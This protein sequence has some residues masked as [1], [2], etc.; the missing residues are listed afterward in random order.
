MDTAPGERS[1]RALRAERN[2]SP[3]PTSAVIDASAVDDGALS[4]SVASSDANGAPASVP[5]ARAENRTPA[6]DEPVTPAVAVLP[7][8]PTDPVRRRRGRAER[9]WLW[10][11]IA[12]AT[13][14]VSTVVGLIVSLAL[15]GALGQSLGGGVA[16]V[17]VAATALAV[18]SRSR[19]PGLLGLRA[20]DILWGLVLGV[21]LPFVA[22][23]FAGGGAWPAYAALSPRWVAT[24]VVAPILTSAFLAV[25][26]VGLVFPA[27]VRALSPRMSPVVTRIVA[28]ALTAVGFAVIPVVFRGDVSGM[29]V[30][31]PIVL[32]VALGVF[33]GL[34]QRLWGALLAA[35]IFSGVW[36][37]LSVLGTLL[38]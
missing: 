20:L 11:A 33:A 25:F 19:L 36:V 24:G 12:G 32:G 16:S 2:A 6:S 30:A 28:G 10:L 15:G 35:A 8:T 31:L 7:S 17:L 38:A 37:A 14:V 9:A 29:P 3:D 23:V 1:R 21:L 13:L 22:G 27:A 18:L 4:A 5:V 26:A 34:S